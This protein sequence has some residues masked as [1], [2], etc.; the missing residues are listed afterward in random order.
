MGHAIGY[1][2]GQGAKLTQSTCIGAE[3][4]IASKSF[5]EGDTVVGK[6][7]GDAVGRGDTYIG[8]NTGQSATGSNNVFIGTAAGKTSTASDAFM[9]QSEYEAPE[10]LLE[11]TFPNTQFK[12]NAERLS[13]YKGVTPVNGPLRLRNSTLKKRRPKKRPNEST[14]SSKT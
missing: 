14:R 3:S 1:F 8:T 2:A 5:G 11:G 7:A 12:I 9:L 6:Q 13:L 4:C 10:P